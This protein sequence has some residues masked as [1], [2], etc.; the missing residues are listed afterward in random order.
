[1]KSNVKLAYKRIGMRRKLASN[2]Y[3]DAI[4]MK[5]WNTIPFLDG[6]ECGLIV[7]EKILREECPETVHL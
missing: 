5:A 3:K 6:F 2:D 7:A 4:K 1:M